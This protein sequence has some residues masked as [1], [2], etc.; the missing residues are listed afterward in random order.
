MYKQKTKKSGF[1][2]IELLIVIVI[3]G[4][5]AA[6]GLRAFAASQMKARDSKRKTDLRTI[7][8]ALEVYYNDLGI[9][10][11]SE[12]NGLIF[13][14]GAQA[15]EECSAGQIW[16]NDD[17]GTTYMVQ[18]PR[19]PSGGMYYYTSDGTY[20]QIYARLEN[21]QDRDIPTDVD[22][23]PL[24]YSVP[25][26]EAGSNACGIG[27]CNYGRSSTNIDLGSTF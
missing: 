7:G 25:N 4:I 9:Y 21:M 1:T 26:S 6:V 8:D 27:H 19:D 18:M 23:N 20:Y 13:G 14:C 16:K 24:N 22:G 5:L 12:N 15:K 17:N 10:P 2:M 11:D 3:I